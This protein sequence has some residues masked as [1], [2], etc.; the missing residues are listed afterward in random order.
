MIDF[1]VACRISY[2]VRKRTVAKKSA[3]GEWRETVSILRRRN[4][5]SARQVSGRGREINAARILTTWTN[6][7]GGQ[8]RGGSLV[9]R[10]ASIKVVGGT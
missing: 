7:V 9:S 3:R 4:G 6:S 5:A 10:Q 2:G 8:R 1:A